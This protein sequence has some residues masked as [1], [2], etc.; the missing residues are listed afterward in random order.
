[1]CNCVCV[2]AHTIVTL[3]TLASYCFNA[4]TA[5][6]DTTTAIS[7]IIPEIGYADDELMN[8][9]ARIMMSRGGGGIGDSADDSV[10]LISKENVARPVNN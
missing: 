3:S 4:A 6:T 1:M 7:R 2:C 9:L 5:I 8:V 10:C